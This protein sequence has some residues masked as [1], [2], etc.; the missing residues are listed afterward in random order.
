[1]VVTGLLTFKAE[2]PVQRVI[3]M[4]GSWIFCIGSHQQ[5]QYHVRRH[6]QQQPFANDSK[7][8]RECTFLAWNSEP[9]TIHGEGTSA[10]VIVPS[11]MPPDEHKR[12]LFAVRVNKCWRWILKSLSFALP[13]YDFIIADSSDWYWLEQ[14]QFSSFFNLN[15]KLSCFQI[16]LI[17][18][19]VNIRSLH[20]YLDSSLCI[21]E[22]E[23]IFSR[24]TIWFWMRETETLK[25]RFWCYHDYVTFLSWTYSRTGCLV[26]QVF[27]NNNFLFELEGV[28][29]H[30]CTRCVSV[31]VHA[32][33][34]LTM[35]Y[36]VCCWN[37]SLATWLVYGSYLVLGGLKQTN[38]QRVVGRF[39]CFTFPRRTKKD[40]IHKT[41]WIRQ[42]K[43][44]CSVRITF[45]HDNQFVANIA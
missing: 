32:D 26:S 31:T 39:C 29:R 8:E 30:K 4:P 6:Q 14:S 36:S 17:Y 22:L 45:A 28:F 2:H 24:E 12:L 40:L 20:N 18:I 35:S 43:I 38:T 37:V 41:L 42:Y 33:L 34:R 3:P 9:G 13:S 11:V 1:M 5:Q 25:L 7:L 19:R 21:H 23:F 27:S 10:Y 15:P 44:S 16:A